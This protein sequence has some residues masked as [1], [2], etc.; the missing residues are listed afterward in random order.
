MALRG[1]ILLVQDMNYYSEY[2]RWLTWVGQ[3]WVIQVPGR[4]PEAWTNFGRQWEKLGYR[5]RGYPR[6][7]VLCLDFQRK[8]IHDSLYFRMLYLTSCAASFLPNMPGLLKLSSSIIQASRM[9]SEKTSRQ[10]SSLFRSNAKCSTNVLR[11]STSLLDPRLAVK[12]TR[13]IE[14][15][16]PLSRNW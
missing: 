5:I 6:V 13:H 12:H 9:K 15:Q 11:L 4:L 7:W 10:K 3:T 14:A 8:Y 16:G 1:E 2:H